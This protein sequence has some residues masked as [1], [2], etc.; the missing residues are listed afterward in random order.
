MAARS[1]PGVFVPSGKDEK[2]RESV[3]ESERGKKSPASPSPSI[4]NKPN[5]KKNKSTTKTQ[6][7][8]K[9]QTGKSSGS[10]KPVA[11][12]AEK[13]KQHTGTSPRKEAVK[14]ERTPKEAVKKEQTSTAPAMYMFSRPKFEAASAAIGKIMGDDM[15]KFVEELL[16]ADGKAWKDN[17]DFVFIVKGNTDTHGLTWNDVSVKLPWFVTFELEKRAKEAKDPASQKLS[18]LITRRSVDGRGK[19]ESADSPRWKKKK[20]PPLNKTKNRDETKGK[21]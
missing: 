14:K 3:K 4:R 13:K 21:K 9:E 2:K 7:K 18:D 16:A 11:G 5:E 6:E 1:E 17:K 8:K 20:A 10:V 19:A 12:K 15:K